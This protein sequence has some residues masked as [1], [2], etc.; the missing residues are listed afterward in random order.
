MLYTLEDAI[1]STVLES[2]ISSRAFLLCTAASLLLG[3]AVAAAQFIKNTPSKSMVTALALLPT[4]VELVIMLVNGNLGVGVAVAGA[5]SLVRFRSA[6]GSAKDIADIF[7]AMAIGLA[8]GTGY[9]GIAA[10]FTVLILGADVFYRCIR[11]GEPRNGTKDLRIVVP[12]TLNYTDIFEDVFARF[13]KSH[14]LQKVKTSSMGSLFTLTYRVELRPDA[15]EKDFIDELRIR[16][17]NLDIVCSSLTVGQ[18]E[19]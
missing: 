9:V 13:T 19:L 2:E 7:I 12:E 4:I 5:F 15:S 11:F 16:N 17:G 8:T 10:V 3:F 18:D 6:A 14:T 1:F